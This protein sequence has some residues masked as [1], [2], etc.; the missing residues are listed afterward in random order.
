MNPEKAKG[1]GIII[2]LDRIPH[3]EWDR[4]FKATKDG[5]P[6][7]KIATT[8]QRKSVE[9]IKEIREHGEVMIDTRL[10]EYLPAI[11]EC[12]EMY[13]PFEPW[14]ITFRSGN[15]YVMRQAQHHKVITIAIAS[16]RIVGTD[17]ECLRRN[18]VTC[19][20]V[21]LQHTKDALQA[22]IRRILCSMRELAV[23]SH[24]LV[25]DD[26]EIIVYGNYLICTNR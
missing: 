13:K 15:E 4:I 18:R 16:V 1:K 7:Y 17:E 26:L 2:N 5:K 23:I 6:I 8:L 14:G 20:E 21:I 9:I 22:G 12:I 24:D 10:G 11:D 3:E 25:R 19:E